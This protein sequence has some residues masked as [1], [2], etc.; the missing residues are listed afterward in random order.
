MSFQQGAKPRDLTF[1]LT[2]GARQT[3]YPSARAAPI[4]AAKDRRKLTSHHLSLCTRLDVVPWLCRS[5]SRSAWLAHRW[6]RPGSCEAGSPGLPWRFQTTSG[7]RARRAR[8]QVHPPVAESYVSARAECGSSACRRDLRTD[9][10]ANDSKDWQD[11]WRVPGL[12][13]SCSVEVERYRCGQPCCS[14]LC[15]VLAGSPSCRPGEAS[16]LR[17]IPIWK[18]ATA[19]RLTGEARS[20]CESMYG[21]VCLCCNSKLFLPARLRWKWI[22]NQAATAGL[23]S[24]WAALPAAHPALASKLEFATAA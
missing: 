17:F 15:A 18:D 13:E 7:P 9:G 3:A 19:G 4:D 21:G 2:V 14:C 12:L 16:T 5:G 6:A 20:H 10:N 22:T 11:L 23:I 1:W 24:L 8:Y